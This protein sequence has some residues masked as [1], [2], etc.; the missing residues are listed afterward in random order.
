MDISQPG[1]DAALDDECTTELVRSVCV[2]PFTYEGI[3]HHTCT[4]AE[5]YSNKAWCAIKVDPEVVLTRHNTIQNENWD[6]C[7][8]ACINDGIRR[9]NNDTYPTF[10]DMLAC[11]KNDNPCGLGEGQCDTNKHCKAGLICGKRNCDKLIFPTNPLGV[12]MDCCTK[13]KRH[14]LL[15]YGLFLTVLLLFAAF[16]LY[17]LMKMKKSKKKDASEILLAQTT[18]QLDP[19]RD[20]KGQ[21]SVIPINMKREIPLSSFKLNEYLGSGQFGSVH[22]GE[23]KENCRTDAVT[24]VAVKSIQGMDSKEDAENFLKEI[25]IMGYLDHHLNLVSMIGSCTVDYK[26]EGQMFLVLEYCMFG[27]LKDFLMEN[28]EKILQGKQCDKINIRSLI[29]WA[30]DISKGMQFLEENQIMH[31]DL[32][33][34]NVLLHKD[35]CN[36]GHSVAKIADFGLAKNFYDNIEY[37]KESRLLI[38]WKWMALEYLLYSVLTLKSDVWSFGIVLWEIFSFGK[39]P[40]G[41]QDMDEVLKKLERGYRLPCP[42]EVENIESSSLKQLY[43]NI[44]KLCFISDPNVRPSFCDVAN[45]IATELIKDELSRYIENTS[46]YQSRYIGNYLHLNKIK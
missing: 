28:K 33:T 3:V 16:C 37:K 7:S 35:P 46:T 9:C 31:G 20:T 1:I 43:N 27:D 34:R 42:S 45:M 14:G 26:K 17:V 19:T 40:Y 8:S 39:T 4:F 15:I 13:R 6:Y 41:H 10:P 29:L 36:K 21:I 22:K 30:Y 25:K 18:N 44:S 12:S 32:A 11:C 5:A 24:T 23:L 38:P 2:F